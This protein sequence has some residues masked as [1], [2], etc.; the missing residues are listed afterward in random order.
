MRTAFVNL[1]GYVQTASDK[2][3]ARKHMQATLVHDASVLHETSTDGV[4]LP[5]QLHED[6]RHDEDHVDSEFHDQSTKTA[7]VSR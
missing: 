7:A 3:D 1:H 2:E 6:V 4:T 5:G